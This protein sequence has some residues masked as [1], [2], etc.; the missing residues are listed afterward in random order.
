[1]ARG[2]IADDRPSA[3]KRRLRFVAIALGTAALLL[4]AWRMIPA[5]PAVPIWLDAFTHD[6]VL[7]VA[8]ERAKYLDL[9]LKVEESREYG[10]CYQS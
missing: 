7:W 10:N 5:F 8:G 6:L 9:G 1:M 3:K 4:L 2:P